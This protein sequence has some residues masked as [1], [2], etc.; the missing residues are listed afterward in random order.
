LKSIVAEWNNAG[1]D[2][3]G[4][5]HLYLLL[6]QSDTISNIDLKNNNI[7]ADGAYIIAK[8]I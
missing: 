8:I 4:L 6:S 2:P 7:K 5:E 3:S 1:G